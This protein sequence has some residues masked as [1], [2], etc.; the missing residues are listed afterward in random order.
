MM[1]HPSRETHRVHHRKPVPPEGGTANEN[2]HRGARR[3]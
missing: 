3:T 1:I 2:L